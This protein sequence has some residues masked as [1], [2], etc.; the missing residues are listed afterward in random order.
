[1]L[2]LIIKRNEI[3]HLLSYTKLTNI[4]SKGLHLGLYIKYIVEIKQTE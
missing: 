2:M 4:L 3:W 1:M